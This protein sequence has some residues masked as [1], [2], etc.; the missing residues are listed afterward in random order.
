MKQSWIPR[1]FAGKVKFSSRGSHTERSYIIP[2]QPITPSALRHPQLEKELDGEE[3]H[4]AVLDPA[5]FRGKSE[6]LF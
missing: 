2:G 5:G 4:K 6:V 1:A 3:Q